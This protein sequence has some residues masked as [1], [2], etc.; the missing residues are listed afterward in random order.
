MGDVQMTRPALLVARGRGRGARW[1]RGDRAV[2][3]A[4]PWPSPT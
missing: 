2:A 1:S 3:W 4:A